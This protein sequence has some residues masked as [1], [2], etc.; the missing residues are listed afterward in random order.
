MALGIDR[1]YNSRTLGLDFYPGGNPKR[2]FFRQVLRGNFLAL[3]LKALKG[4][5]N[6]AY[7]NWFYP[8]GTS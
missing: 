5:I 7:F 8:F 3:E 1:V 6:Q 2:T 4:L